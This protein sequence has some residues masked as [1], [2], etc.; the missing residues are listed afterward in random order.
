MNRCSRAIRLHRARRVMTV[1]PNGNERINVDQI[2][3]T[4]ATLSG[5]KFRA[6]TRA[7]QRGTGNPPIR[8]DRRRGSHPTGAR[9]QKRVRVLTFGRRA[10]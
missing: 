10:A 3:S 8:P 2:L 7:F 6:F 1:M 9:W 5:K 4:I